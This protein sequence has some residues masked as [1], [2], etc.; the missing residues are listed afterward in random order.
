MVDFPQVDET[1]TV[2]LGDIV[3]ERA[4][5]IAKGY[6]AGHDDLHDGYELS[7]AAGAYILYVSNGIPDGAPDDQWP[8]DVASF[9]PDDDEYADLLKAATLLVAELQRIH[10]ARN[11]LAFHRASKLL[12]GGEHA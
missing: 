7:N 6:D 9:C 12:G 8:W 4:R 11:L 1:L 3:D 10:R 5:Q 2:V